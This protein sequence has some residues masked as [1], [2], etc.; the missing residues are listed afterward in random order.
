MA[1]QHLALVWT[2]GSSLKLYID[3]Q[4]NT[5]SY[6]MGPVSGNVSGVTKLMLGRGTKSQYWNGMIDELGIYNRALDATE[7]DNIYQQ[8]G[9]PGGL[10]AHWKLDESGNSSS[11]ITAAAGKSAIIV[12]QGGVAQKWGQAVDAF[13]R[14]IERN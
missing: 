3:G 7:V 4:L 14:S 1:W 9:S 12:W 10:L 8:T 11:T 2:S 5:L 13:F 6:D